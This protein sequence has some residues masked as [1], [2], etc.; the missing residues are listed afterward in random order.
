MNFSFFPYGHETQF[1]NVDGSWHFYCQHGQ[2]E[3]DEN[4]LEA[5]A[6]HFHP[7]GGAHNTYEWWPFVVCMEGAEEGATPDVAAGTCA[8]SL[9]WSDYESNIRPCWQ[10]STGLNSLGNDIMHEIGLATEALKPKLDFTPWVVLE[11]TPLTADQLD[12]SLIALICK[13]YTGPKPDACNNATL[14]SHST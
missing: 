1:Q 8:Q 13:A 9:G 14:A 2:V 6:R 3:C 10:N 4:M 7:K 12:L 5:C 11:G